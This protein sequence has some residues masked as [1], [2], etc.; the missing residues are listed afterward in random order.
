MNKDGLDELLAIS[1]NRYELQITA[2]WRYAQFFNFLQISPS[3]R[4]AH[5][6]ATAKVDRLSV[7]LPQDFAIVE[8]TYEA[9]GDVWEIGFWSWWIKRAQ[10]QF[11]ISVIPTV[12]AIA[13]VNVGAEIS[14][15]AVEKAQAELEQYLLA[16]RLAEGKPASLIVAVP[17][18]GDRRKILNQFSEMLDKFYK[19]TEHQRGIAHYQVNRNK[20]REQT[21][22]NAM[23]VLRA[24]AALPKKPLFVIGNKSKI[25]PAYE[26]DENKRLRNDEY[27]RLMEILTS[28]QLHRAYLYSEHAARGNFP[29]IDPLPNDDGRPD[30]NY[31]SL[32]RQ[33]KAQMRWME[34]EIAR[35]KRIDAARK[36]N[37]L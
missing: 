4:L 36:A 12:H 3:Y 13:T 33:L 30:F 8:K 18:H 22:K 14:K 31:V 24:R 10:Y 21:L 34:A 28:R 16:D 5:L 37:N 25:A 11:G 27:R 26:T 20:I 29:C 32:Q 19:P 17:L 23:R 2:D 1:R 9:L 35:L 15:D 7:K 6:I